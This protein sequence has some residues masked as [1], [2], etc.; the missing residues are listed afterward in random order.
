MLS[1]LRAEVA[2]QN[3]FRK[4]EELP[5]VVEEAPVVSYQFD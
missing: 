3:S 1:N 2:Q 4:L 5:P